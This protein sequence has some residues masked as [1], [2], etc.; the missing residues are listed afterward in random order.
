MVF[1]NVPARPDI[2]MFFMWPSMVE[3]MPARN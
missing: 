1:D 3:V 2:L